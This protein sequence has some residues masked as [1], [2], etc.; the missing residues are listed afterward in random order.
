MLHKLG[1]YNVTQYAV[2]IVEN[3]RIKGKIL[4]NRINVLIEDIKHSKNQDSSLKWRKYDQKK[5]EAKGKGTWVWL[6]HQPVPSREAH[7]VRTSEL[8]PIPYEI[9]P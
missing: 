8:E 9:M 4:A 2:G 1:V 3:K 6:K 7:F 5:K